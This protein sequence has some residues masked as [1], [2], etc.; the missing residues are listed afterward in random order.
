MWRERKNGNHAILSR[1]QIVI[2]GVPY[3]HQFYEKYHPTEQVVLEKRE[4]EIYSQ[5]D[6]TKLKE[7]ID[8]LR[9]SIE[10]LRRESNLSTREIE[11]KTAEIHPPKNEDHITGKTKKDSKKIVKFDSNWSLAA[12]RSPYKSNVLHGILRTKS[13]LSF[14]RIMNAGIKLHTPRQTRIIICLTKLVRG[15]SL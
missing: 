11:S 2:N 3:D 13:T 8:S 15:S 14:E 1:D 7:G 10:I 5:E 9:N 12:S 6:L 4:K